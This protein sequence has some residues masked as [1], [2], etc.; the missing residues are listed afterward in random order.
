M[1]YCANSTALATLELRVH[2][3]LEDL[4]ILSR[5][6]IEAPDELLPA[7][8]P[9]YFPDWARSQQYGDDWIKSRRSLC[10]K[11]LSAVIP[12]AT[13]SFNILINPAHPESGRV[14]VLDIAPYEFDSRLF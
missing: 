9:V 2:Y 10:L 1:L 5:S 11:V 3:E 6:I 4:P 7:D 14:R 8:E 13:D 12:E